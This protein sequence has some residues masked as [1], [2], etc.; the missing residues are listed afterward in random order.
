MKIAIFLILLLFTLLGCTINKETSIQN[1]NT[2]P[3]IDLPLVMVRLDSSRYFLPEC[4]PPIAIPKRLLLTLPTIQEA[5]LSGF[6]PAAM[7]KKEILDR[8]LEKEL[9]VV[10]EIKPTKETESRRIQVLMLEAASDK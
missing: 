9:S 1:D 7:C 2:Q 5:D 8:R 4:P 6:R 3:K 10:G